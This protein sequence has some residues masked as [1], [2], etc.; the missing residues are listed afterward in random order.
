[1]KKMIRKLTLIGLAVVAA[2]VMSAKVAIADEKLDAAM[3]AIKIQRK[4][5]IEKAM[6]LSPQEK[7]AFW[8]LYDEY[9]AD[10]SIVRGKLFKLF[11]DFF[12][13]QGYLSDEEALSMLSENLKIEEE[14]GK[15]VHVYLAKFKKILPGRK[16][17]RLYQLETRF[18]T[19]AL[20]AL[21]QQIPVIR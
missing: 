8:A 10:L 7:E 5:Y 17:L 9:H 18:D 15:L 11:A 20:S 1:M 6:E 21:Q 19:A 3:E 4:A 16:V 2:M 13:K 14:E 12:E